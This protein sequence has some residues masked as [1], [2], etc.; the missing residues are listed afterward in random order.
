MAEPDVYV[1]VGAMTYSKDTTK[2]AA[3]YAVMAEKLM[4]EAAVGAIHGSPGFT[5]Y[6]VGN[7]DGY[8]LIA[9]LTEVS[10]GTYQGQPSVTSYLSGEV[11]TYPQPKMLTTSLTGKGMIGGGT[12]DGDVAASIKEAMKTMVLKSVI[13]YLKTKPKA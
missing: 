8:Y 12:T 10:F 1:D 2:V 7:P 13:P 3:K 6:K 4:K 11:G 9:K 5:P